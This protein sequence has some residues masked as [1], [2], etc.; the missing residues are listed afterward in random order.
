[1]KTLLL[2]AWAVSAIATAAPS[3]TPQDYTHLLP[4]AAGARQGVLQL[5]L[6]KE[7]YLH[8]R[9][10]MLDDV[11]VF[12]AKGAVQ[13]FALRTLV[14]EARSSHRDLP[15]TI[16]PLMSVAGP[17][18][19]LDLDV[20]TAAD[21]RL[22]SVKVRPDQERDKSSQQ[23]RLAGLVLD[24]GKEAAATPVNA[25]R[26]TLPAGQQEYN[27]QVWLET[28]N[29]MKR[30]DTVGAAELNWLVNQNAQTLANDRLDFDARKFRY[31]RLSWRS[32]T[33][34]QFAGITAEQPLQADAAPPGEQLL[35][36]PAAGREPKDLVYAAP[37]AVAPLKVGLQFSEANVV[38]AGTLGV[39]RDLP[40][41]QVGQ[42]PSWRFDPL[43]SST[44]Y[45]ITQNDQV[46]S[47]GD[48]EVPAVH[49]AQWVL[50]T[51]APGTARP[52]LRM[53]WQP[54]T[55]VFLASGNAPYTLAV[56]R[57]RA[58]PAAQSIDQVAP[59]FSEEE[60]K[61]VALATA[62]PAAQQQGGGAWDAGAALEAATAAKRRLIVLWGVLLLGV[63]V[64]G[65]MVWRLLRPSRS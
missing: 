46:R 43:V 42:G 44:F 27:A 28:S 25:L 41:R 65:F 19:Q 8:A 22:L 52:A 13:P 50:R 34:L 61:K 37:P 17:A 35:L 7:V 20:S 45:R 12:D 9:S 32:G 23:P 63:G 55:L 5:R 62:G 31:A 59:G 11:R 29:D 36:L 51:T 30:W 38:L 56:G 4:L 48:L 3:D 16:F 1:M 53:T 10:P 60:L 39:Y 14:F 54:A 33:P 21:G 57:E 64:L 18:S 40:A 49:A 24:L 2:A 47:S 6:P 58:T 26:F 15:L